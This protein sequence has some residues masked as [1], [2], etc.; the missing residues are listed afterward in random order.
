MNV[1]K[2][3]FLNMLRELFLD[4]S[5]E[6]MLMQWKQLCKANSSDVNWFM[7]EFEKSVYTLNETNLEILHKNEFPNKYVN[8]DSVDE[9]KMN[10]EEYK[11]FMED[12]L[13]KMK[14]IQYHTIRYK[15]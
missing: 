8:S 13:K 15:D 1:F 12:L 5:E 2:Y 7:N 6:E 3:D 4:N 14:R 11:I 9:R 10:L